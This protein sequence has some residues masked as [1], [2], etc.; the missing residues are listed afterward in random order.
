M[1]KEHCIDTI[2]ITAPETAFGLPRWLSTALQR[3]K[4]WMETHRQRQR[5]ASLDDYM[6]RDLG[7]TRADVQTEIEKPFWQL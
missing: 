1:K 4:R 6:L 2:Q 5:L 3:L 7:L